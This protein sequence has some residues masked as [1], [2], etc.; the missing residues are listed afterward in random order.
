MKST[1]LFEVGV[2][3]LLLGVFAAPRLF[4]WSFGNLLF[5][6]PGGICIIVGLLRVGKELKSK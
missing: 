4:H 3:L 5:E 6:I 2:L 1:T